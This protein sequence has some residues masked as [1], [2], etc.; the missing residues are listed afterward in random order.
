MKRFF[1]GITVAGISLS[2]LATN[3]V[4][5]AV[6]PEVAE[7]EAKVTAAEQRALEAEER[8]AAAEAELSEIRDA[9]PWE[10]FVPPEDTKYDWV[11][12]PSGEW[13]KGDLKVM[14]N[15]VLEFDSDELD[16]Q[17][18]DF[19]DIIQLRTRRP[20]TVLVER[21]PRD[22]ELAV[23]RISMIEDVMI[24]HG[25]EGDVEIKRHEIVSIAGGSARERDRWSGSFSVGI[26]ARGGNT[27]TTDVNTMAN[28]K[29]RSAMTR[30]NVD[31]LANYSEADNKDPAVDNKTADNQR[32][33]GY[34]DWF[35]TSRFYWQVLAGEYYRDPFSNIRG[36]YSVSSGIGYDFIRS[37]RTEWTVNMG[38]GYQEMQFDTVQAPE[39]NNSSSPFFTTGTRLDYEVSGNIDFLYDY[40]LRILNEDN[41]DYTHHMIATLSVELIKDL[42]LDLSAIWDRIDSPQPIDDGVNPVTVPE[43]DDYQ[44]VVSLAYDF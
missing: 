41:G 14:Y 3:E 29:R 38:I 13:L 37:P 6:N 10:R 26:T 30:L 19:D 17:E 20:Q 22:T 15:Y 44:L 32:L 43:K 18:L 9:D 39:D 42:D 8:A 31:Y 23:G 7:A 34:F 28:V 5:T 33:S 1:Y 12:L 36:Q 16:L 4:A 40:N 11:Q 24:L 21:G 2:S 35:L 27:E 25:T